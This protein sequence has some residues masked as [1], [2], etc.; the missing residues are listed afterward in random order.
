VPVS[1]EAIRG[2]AQRIGR[3][4]G[5]DRVVLFGSHARGEA[6]ED[7]DVDLLVVSQTDL[8]RHKR[9]RALYAL[10]DPYPFPMDIIVYTPAEITQALNSPASFVATVLAE[11]REIYAGSWGEPLG[12]LGGE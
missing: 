1:K 4:A 12:P 3:A 5:A 10:F 8:P 9:S 6:R 7:S 2:V 11:G